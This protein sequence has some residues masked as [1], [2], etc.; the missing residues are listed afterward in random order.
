VISFQL[1]VRAVSFQSVQPLKRIQNIVLQAGDVSRPQ[2]Q[3]SLRACEDCESARFSGQKAGFLFQEGGF[4]AQKAAKIGGLQL[5]I[6]NW[7]KFVN[8]SIVTT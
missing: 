4:F 2:F 7:G 1:S 6:S 5:P 3:I 8:H